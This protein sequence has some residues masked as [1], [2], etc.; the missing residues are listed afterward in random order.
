MCSANNV[1]WYEVTRNDQH[2]HHSYLCFYGTAQGKAR[3]NTVFYFAS[4]CFVAIL[5]DHLDLAG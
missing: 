3:T 1:E 2:T 5:Y 4:S